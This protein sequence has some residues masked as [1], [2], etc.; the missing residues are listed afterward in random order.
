VHPEN[1]GK[2]P[3]LSVNRGAIFD[4]NAAAAIED[5]LTKATAQNITVAA[6]P[7]GLVVNRRMISYK[8]PGE[9]IVGEHCR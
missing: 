6:Q 7:Q 3:P 8:G 4:A 9:S 1:R 5:L 2:K